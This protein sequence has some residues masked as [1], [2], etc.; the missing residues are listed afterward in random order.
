MERL[1]AKLT[2]Q[3]KWKLTDGDG[4]YKILDGIWVN[5]GEMGDRKLAGYLHTVSFL[6]SV[7]L[8]IC[9]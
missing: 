6:S 3:I 7:M 2:E 5:N 4:S 9:S 8:S 1:D